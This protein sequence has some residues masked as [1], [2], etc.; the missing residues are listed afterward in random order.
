MI[1]VKRQGDQIASRS[2]RPRGCWWG[3]AGV[4]NVRPLSFVVLCGLSLMILANA[5]SAEQIIVKPKDGKQN[6]KKEQRDT[7][8]TPLMVRILPPLG[9]NEPP[10]DYSK[11]QHDYSSG[12]WWLVYLTGTL[13]AFTLGLMIYTAKL[14]GSTKNAVEEAKAVSSRQAKEMEESLRIANDTAAAAKRTAEVMERQ[15]QAEIVLHEM[16]I[17]NIPDG[18]PIGQTRIKNV[19]KTSARNVVHIGGV[20]FREYEVPLEFRLPTLAL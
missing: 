12:E 17:L 5:Q 9:A 2:S 11:V 16:Q 6:A 1:T 20:A 3:K 13:A 7:E 14:W 19:G 4:L 8:S 10:S 15:V 18:I